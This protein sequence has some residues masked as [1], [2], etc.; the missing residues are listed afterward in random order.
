MNKLRER[1]TYLEEIKE[2]ELTPYEE[3]QC[4][5][6][7]FELGSV[8]D[9]INEPNAKAFL[10]EAKEIIGALAGRR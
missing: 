7:W 4:D 5:R 9:S 10:E 3:S 1:Q 6:V 8:I 2:I